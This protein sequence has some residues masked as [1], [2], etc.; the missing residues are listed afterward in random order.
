MRTFSISGDFLHCHVALPAGTCQDFP[1]SSEKASLKVGERQTGDQFAPRITALSCRMC[2]T[3]LSATSSIFKD[4]LAIHQVGR[5]C[6]MRL[7]TAKTTQ[8][9][10]ALEYAD[11]GHSFYSCVVQYAKPDKRQF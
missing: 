4:L 9:E 1:H 8:S 7:Q 2:P 11:K 10:Q 5:P 6:C 3:S